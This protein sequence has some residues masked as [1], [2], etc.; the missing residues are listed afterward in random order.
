MKTTMRK[1]QMNYVRWWVLDLRGT[2]SEPHAASTEQ[3]VAV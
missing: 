1:H 3:E 2:G